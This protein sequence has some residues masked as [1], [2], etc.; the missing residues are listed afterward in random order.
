MI[1]QPRYAEW[2]RLSHRTARFETFMVVAVQ[3]LGRLD[4]VL[5]AKDDHYLGLSDKER[6]EF[7]VSL[8]L[9]DRFTE[10]YLW[11]LGA[12]EIIRSIDQRCRA[13]ISLVSDSTHVRSAK[14]YFER[15]RIPLAK[16]EPARRF[17]AT[18]SR[19]AYPSIDRRYGIAWQVADQTF[20]SRGELSERFLGLLRS[21]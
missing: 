19:I 12:Y 4:A 15:V 8:D 5:T 1:D 14:E 11:V 16:F 13:D 17:R 2:V 10:S 21:L 9:T 20:I 18:D 7:E 3:G 6:D